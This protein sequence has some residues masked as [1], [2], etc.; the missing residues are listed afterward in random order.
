MNTCH[1]TPPRFRHLALAVLLAAGVPLAAEIGSVSA[2]D[3]IRA[4][5]NGQIITQGDVDLFLAGMKPTERTRQDQVALNHLVNGVL[6]REKAKELG[7]V[8]P[9]QDIE[10]RVD[11]MVP[12]MDLPRWLIRRLVEEEE[13]RRV[14]RQVLIAPKVRVTPEEIRAYYDTHTT[15]FAAPAQVLIRVIDVKYYPVEAIRAATEDVRSSLTEAAALATDR[16]RVDRITALNARILAR[17]GD[18]AENLGALKALVRDLLESPDEFLRL[19]AA[20][21][22]EK[23]QTFKT[24]AEAA[25]IGEDALARLRNGEDFEAVVIRYAEGPFRTNGGTW[26]WFTAGEL[27]VKLAAIEAAAFALGDQAT[28]GILD[29][30]G[31]KYII[32]KTGAKPATCQEVSS[33]EVQERITRTLT[34]Q[35]LQQAEEELWKELRQTAH[36]QFMD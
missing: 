31:T 8:L 9:E 26:N 6:L 36:I 10:K 20:K 7:V 11:S 18:R 12:N 17:A 2:I 27:S 33:P 3:R 4:V 29:A 5:V 23:Y 32:R 24:E 25:A 30:A 34:T 14:I 15:D 13:L 1:R 19:A 22:N 16:E 28:S 35:A 21:L